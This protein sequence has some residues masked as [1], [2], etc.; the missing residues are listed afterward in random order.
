MRFGILGGAGPIA[1]AHFM[2]TVLRTAVA[3]NH[4]YLDSDFPELVITSIGIKDGDAQ[5]HFDSSALESHLS[6][7]L[8]LLGSCDYIAV[9]C[10]TIS[11]HQFIRE[12]A[13]V[14]NNVVITKSFITT[15]E[16]VVIASEHALDKDVWQL[17]SLPA[18][19]QF[20]VTEA[21]KDAMQG[22]TMPS[23]DLLLALKKVPE[24]T[25]I[26]LGCTELTAYASSLRDFLPHAIVDS[27]ESLSSE[28]L[29]L[30]NEKK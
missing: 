29:R 28:I 7:G 25:T 6:Q 9:A 5:A 16:A 14:L 24:D 17:P 3:T 19:E 18:E 10:N 20:I 30:H 2:S 21:I 4:V 23:E 13:R 8:S 12:D 1:T 22:E 15:P 27:V 11:Q 26:V